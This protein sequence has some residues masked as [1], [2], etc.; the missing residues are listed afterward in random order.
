[1]AFITRAHGDAKP[2]FST[3]TLNGS[4]SAT[5]GVPVMLSGP[6]LDFFGIDLGAD[7]ATEMD[8]DEAIE[9]VLRVITSVATVHFYQVEASGTANNMSVAVYQSSSCT[10]SGLQAAIRELGTVSGYTLSGATVTNVGFK[11]AT[12]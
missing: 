6:K 4:G 12:A 9:A 1:M 10:A 11:L 3:D 8:P 5:T 7:P 2:V